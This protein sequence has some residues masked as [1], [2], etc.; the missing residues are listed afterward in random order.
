MSNGIIEL[1]PAAYYNMSAFAEKA[2]KYYI[3]IWAVPPMQGLT[4]KLLTF[5]TLIIIYL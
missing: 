5:L 2:E 1:F 4:Q 3:I